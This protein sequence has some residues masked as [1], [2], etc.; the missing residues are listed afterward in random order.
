MSTVETNTQRL[1]VDQSAWKITGLDRFVD[2]SLSVQN[3]GYA[4]ELGFAALDAYRKE[5]TPTRECIAAKLQ[6]TAVL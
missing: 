3:S 4:T 2:P 5:G 1:R 6:S